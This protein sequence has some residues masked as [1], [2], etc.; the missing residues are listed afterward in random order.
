MP[1]LRFTQSTYH[2]LAESLRETLTTQ[3]THNETLLRLLQ[4][5]RS[6]HIEPT[7]LIQRLENLAQAA[8]S[9]STQARLLLTQEETHYALTRKRNEWEANKRNA[10][11]L[12][13]TIQRPTAPTP[14]E[15]TGA[16]SSSPPSADWR[17]LERELIADGISPILPVEDRPSIDRTKLEPTGLPRDYLA[18][19]NNSPESKTLTLVDETT[20]ADILA[21]DAQ[22]DAQDEAQRGSMFDD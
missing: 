21:L 18:N 10:F 2:T 7:T 3:A 8:P 15:W 11:K 16:R 6:G 9:A 19:A 13:H 17:A 1:P 14:A 4:Q 22:I 12:Q 5:F 20:T